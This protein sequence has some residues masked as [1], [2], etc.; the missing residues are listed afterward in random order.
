M[1]RAVDKSVNSIFA[2]PEFYDEK[3]R[4][5]FTQKKI[6]DEIL[7]DA[8]PPLPTRQVELD[9]LKQLEQEFRNDRWL[10]LRFRKM[11]AGPLRRPYKQTRALKQKARTQYV[12]NFFIGAVL[13]SPIAIWVGR[14]LRYSSTGVPKTYYPINYHRFPDVNPDKFATRYF[15]I[16][17]FVTLFICGNLSASLLTPTFDR[18]EYYSRP[19]FKPSA[20]MVEESDD[21]K[22]AKKEMMFTEY[23]IKDPEDKKRGILYRLFR[24]NSA[25]YTIH[26]VTK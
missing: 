11:Q 14:S 23:G 22:K 24:P 20:P 16:G 9:Y 21:I 12:M 17:F 19:D 10:H 5:E 13:G 4:E 3:Q 8:V 18:D 25:N 26:P 6:Q 15:R 1:P 2:R 7:E